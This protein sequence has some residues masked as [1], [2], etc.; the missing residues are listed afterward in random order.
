M[1]RPLVAVVLAAGAAKRFWPFVANKTFFPFLGK[2]MFDISTLATLPKKVDRVVVISSTQNRETVGALKFDKPSLTV[3][4]PQPLG[5]ADAL[6]NAKAQLKDSRLLIIIADD[7]VSSDLYSK[8]IAYADKANVFAVIPGWRPKNYFPGGYLKV[9]GK[10][11]LGIIEKPLAHELPSPYVAVSGH[12][13]H[14]SN[15]LLDELEKTHSDMD[16]VYERALTMLAVREKIH[17]LPYDGEFG[18]LKYPWNVLDVMHVLW[19]ENFKA[20]K[21]KNVEIK[22]NVIIEGPVYLGNNV[23]IFENTKI[24]GPVYI[25]DNTIVGNNNIIRESYIGADCVT[26]FNT[27]ITRSY[28]GDA[29]WFHSNYIGDSVL[30]GNI[31]MGSGTVCANLRLDDGE[32]SSMIREAKVATGKSKLGSMI[33]KGVRIGVNASIMPGVK[34][35]AD[36]FIGAG[37]VVDRDIAEKS[38]V[39]SVKNSFTITP[40]TKEGPSADREEFKKYL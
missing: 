18:S 23:R 10:Q 31:S 20:F 3:L 25:G 7:V 28:V 22:E 30:E 21:G 2:S 19:K 39:A 12:Y 11:V 16:D 35:G 29:C 37:I 15:L 40:N 17:V 38:F 4:Q 5:M 13:I 14:D 34:I 36:S 27:D 33:A 9:D 1:N 8:V 6:L 24:V 26:G 32:I